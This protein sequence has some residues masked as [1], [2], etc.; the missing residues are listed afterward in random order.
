M[1]SV[2]DLKGIQK[3]DFQTYRMGILQVFKNVVGDINKLFTFPI[4]S[5]NRKQSLLN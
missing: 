2:H 1:L 3:R 5:Q 4:H